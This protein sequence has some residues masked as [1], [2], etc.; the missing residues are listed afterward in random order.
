[1]MKNTIMTTALATLVTLLLFGCTK[2][3]PSHNTTDLTPPTISNHKPTADA[4]KNQHVKKGSVVTLDATQSTDIE[5]YEQLTYVW[6]IKSKPSSST[7]TLSSTT[8]DKPTFT[9]DKTGEYVLALVVNDGTVDSDKVEITITVTDVSANAKPVAHAGKDQ[10]TKEGTLVTLDATQ[11]SDADSADTVTYV[12][13]IKSKPSGSAATLSSTTVDKP[14]FTADKPGEY[15]LGLV[16]NDGTVDSDEDLV[17]VI[18][19]AVSPIGYNTV[20]SPYTNKTWLDRNVGAS[21]ACTAYNDSAC[22]GHL[23]NWDTNWSKADGS[24]VCPV[25]YRVPTMEEIKAE[26]ISASSPVI[27]RETAFTNFLKLPSAGIN[28]GYKGEEGTLAS[29]DL[30]NSKVVYFLFDKKAMKV[31]S[32]SKKHSL[33]VR[34]IKD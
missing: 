8:V 13:N 28:S 3:S 26:T 15:V 33:S 12:W 18:A 24:S 21:Q 29:S 34:C 4:G 14:T 10:H 7:A 30:N 2:D 11:S 23:L 25:G 9:A 1:M 17:V 16:V 20:A 31:F 5:S 32:G 6:N 27:N 19:T 22:Y